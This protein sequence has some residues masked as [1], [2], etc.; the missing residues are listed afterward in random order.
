MA[1]WLGLSTLTAVAW[2]QCLMGELRTHKLQGTAERNTINLYFPYSFK[3][4]LT[5]RLFLLK[6]LKL[7]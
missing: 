4:L 5:E 3:A 1:L 2:V 6:Y 7:F